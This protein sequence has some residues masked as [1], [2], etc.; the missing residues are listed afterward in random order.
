MYAIYGNIYHEY[1]PNVSIY[2]STMDPMGTVQYISICHYDGNCRS[3]AQT[4][5]SMFG[6]K[7]RRTESPWTSTTDCC[8]VHFCCAPWDFQ[9][10]NFKNFFNK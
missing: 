6:V 4:V 7:S 2:T 1:T 10:S 3:L 8:D 9:S 5:R